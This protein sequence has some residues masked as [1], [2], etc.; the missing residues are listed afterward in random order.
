M[1]EKNARTAIAA[2]AKAVGIEPE[3]IAAGIAAM[4]GTVLKTNTPALAVQ[5]ARVC[6]MLACSRH[7][8]RK[9]ERVGLLKP[10]ELAGLK[11]YLVADI[12]KLLG[13]N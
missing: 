3:R 1:L 10:I 5:Q 4:E 9:L 7:H 6:E 2:T 8:V 11:R 12:I 13:N